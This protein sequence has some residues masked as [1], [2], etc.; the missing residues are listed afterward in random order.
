MWTLVSRGREGLGSHQEP[1]PTRRTVRGGG[2]QDSSPPPP[3][4]HPSDSEPSLSWA[5]L[6]IDLR[7]GVSHG[8][9]EGEPISW[10]SAFVRLGHACT[11]SW[12]KHTHTHTLS[13]W[14]TYTHKPTLFPGSH[15]HTDTH[16]HTQ[17]P[18]R[19]EPLP[20][21]AGVV[22]EGGNPCLQ[23]SKQTS[24]TCHLTP[25]NMQPLLGG[26]RRENCRC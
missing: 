20:E 13:S 11:V 1:A 19:P 21:K 10:S 17:C 26:D 14:C 3:H 7:V 16:T 24:P 22:L 25:P 18:H 6:L 23:V 8:P 15:T 4:P 2:P 5:P 9:Q 12:F